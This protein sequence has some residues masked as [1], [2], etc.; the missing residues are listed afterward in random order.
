MKTA[1]RA[2]LPSGIIAEKRAGPTR[3]D[4]PHID[5][6]KPDGRKLVQKNGEPR[7]FFNVLCR[8]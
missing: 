2:G 1:V 3:T 8:R 4:P 7:K 5:D 6:I